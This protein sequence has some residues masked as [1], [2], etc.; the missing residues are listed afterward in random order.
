MPFLEIKD[1]SNFRMHYEIVPDCLPQDTLF[2]HGN[3][4]SNLWWYPLRDHLISKS[5][6]NSTLIIHKN[7]QINFPKD[8]SSVDGL[9]AGSTSEGLVASDGATAEHKPRLTGKMILA[10][11][12]GCGRSILYSGKLNSEF[13]SEPDSDSEPE[14][15]SEYARY[16]K[17][18]PAE[19]FEKTFDPG[20]S[21]DRMVQD[22]QDLIIELKNQKIILGPISIV[23]HS[24][25]GLIAG[26]LLA[27]AP[28]LFTKALLLDPVGMKGMKFSDDILKSFKRVRFDQK[29]RD[30]I[31]AAVIPKEYLQQPEYFN[32]FILQSMRS[33]DQIGKIIV[34][35]MENVDYTEKFRQIKTPV[36]VVHGS[37]DIILPIQDSREMAAT[38]PGA[39]FYVA[40]GYGHSMNA[41][42]PAAFAELMQQFCY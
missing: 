38:I 7:I 40:E 23:G 41:E 33:V 2:I 24:T 6:L 35:W 37:K 15:E 22:F 28:T 12:R 11:F 10:E 14:S 1:G 31:F 26:L 32:E 16:L 36:M 34:H 21:F 3:I 39:Q 30:Q 5:N 19:E 17:K 18:Y 25:G 4:A 20:F 13:A 8:Q 9:K 27:Q 29:F 42:N